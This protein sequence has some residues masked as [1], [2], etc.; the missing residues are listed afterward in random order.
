M[1]GATLTK[2]HDCGEQL[3]LNCR[4]VRVELEKLKQLRAPAIL[5]WNF[6]HFL[7]L[8]EGT[9]YLNDALQRQVLANLGVLGIT[10]IAVTHDPRVV[11]CTDRCVRI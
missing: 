5:H 7:L 3:D 4:A 9:A 10:V 2:L 8:D 11:E 1:R 6:D